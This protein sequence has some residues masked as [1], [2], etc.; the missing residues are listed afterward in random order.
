MA[1][2]I[3]TR[4][5]NRILLS[6]LIGLFV[7]TSLVAIAHY[8]GDDGGE[9]LGSEC[10]ALCLALV[11]YQAAFFLVLFFFFLL[12]AFALA[13]FR[14]ASRPHFSSFPIPIRAP[15]PDAL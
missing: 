15:P 13:F 2:S 11:H 8:H 14:E 12:M 3:M 1:C 10:C 4:R 5:F 7:W 9:K 6:L